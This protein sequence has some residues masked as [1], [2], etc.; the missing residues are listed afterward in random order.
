MDKYTKTTSSKVFMN[1]A[2]NAKGLL[3][4]PPDG[5]ELGGEELLLADDDG[6][7]VLAVVDGDARAWHPGPRGQ[8]AVDGEQL[9]VAAVEEG[10]LAGELVRHHVQVRVH[11][12]R[13]AA[14]DVVQR[15]PRRVVRVAHE[16]LDQ[17]R[18]H[19]AM[20]RTYTAISHGTH[21]RQQ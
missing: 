4:G 8:R 6:D 12:R 7:V 20:H 15:V 21:D 9:V 14:D 1:E 2:S 11:P 17:E 3:V 19:P 13:A 5:L 10:H 18:P 16:R